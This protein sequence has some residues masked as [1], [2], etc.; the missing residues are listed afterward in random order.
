[1]LLIVAATEPELRGAP[2][3]AGVERYACGVGPVEA[4][5]RTAARLARAPRPSA[6]LHVGVAGAHRASRIRTGALVLGSAATYCDSTS[7][8]VTRRLEPDPELLDQATRAL[9]QALART[10]GTSAD[11]GGSRDCEVEAMEGFGVLLAAGL[12]GVPALELRAVSNLVDEPDRGRWEL[13]LALD[14]LDAALPVLVGA[15][16]ARC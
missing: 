4:A 9:P 2:E 6:V 11:V 14:A 5:A 15:L 1:M 12:A 16:D 10:I 3:L 13:D 7:R 8:L